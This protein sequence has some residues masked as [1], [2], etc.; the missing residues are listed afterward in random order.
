MNPICASTV[1]VMKDHIIKEQKKNSKK[2]MSQD[3]DVVFFAK[4]IAMWTESWIVCFAVGMCV[5]R[6]LKTKMVEALMEIEGRYA[7]WNC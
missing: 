5:L 6:L 4:L 1:T 2:K 3:V 7:E